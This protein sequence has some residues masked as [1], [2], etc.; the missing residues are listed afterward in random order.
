MTLS[1]LEPSM[2]FFVSCN[3]DMSHMMSHHTPS[4]KFKI[5]KIKTKNKIKGK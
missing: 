3:C 1:I 4:P 5:I 2:I